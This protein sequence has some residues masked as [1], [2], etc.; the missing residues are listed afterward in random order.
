MKIA[1]EN[2]MLTI[3]PISYKNNYT[4]SKS[5]NHKEDMSVSNPQ[6]KEWN[7]AYYMPK[8]IS[9]GTRVVPAD[10]GYASYKKLSPEVKNVYKMV[11]DNFYKLIDISELY[12]TDGRTIQSKLPL[13]REEDMKDFLKVAMA[14][15]KYR[16][17]E[18]TG[19][20]ANKIICLGR[21]PKWFLGASL[22]MKGGIQDYTFTAFS[23]NWYHRNGCGVGDKLF[24]DGDKEPTIEQA[25]MYKQY[26]KRIGSD[27]VSL[28]EAA[29]E[30][31]KPVIITDYAH[32]GCG[33]TSW[34]DMMSKYAKDDGVLDDFAKSIRLHV[35]SSDDYI[36]NVLEYHNAYP[37]PCVLMPEKLVKYNIPQDYYDMSAEVLRTML[38]DKNTNECRSTFYPPKAW[39]LYTPDRFQI[40][41]TGMTPEEIRDAYLYQKKFGG[42]FPSMDVWSDAMKDYRN[43]MNFR[44]LNYLDEHGMLDTR[45]MSD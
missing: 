44:I 6:M 42:V 22:W 8:N 31:Q 43:V 9:F 35:I 11:Y 37:H 19:E 40:A 15:N 26:L 12:W 5:N 38:V 45:E 18:E 39:T 17:N 28:V 25:F 23:S 2:T 41:Q 4:L 32:S 1:R 21:S 33:V 7:P 13:S 36:D 34:L 16:G 20:K 14:Y 3:S 29:Q 10:V 30:T 27:P 24:R